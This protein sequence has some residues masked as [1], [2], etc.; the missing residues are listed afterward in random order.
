VT[1]E[2]PDRDLGGG[3]I[4][5]AH[6][7][8][9]LARAMP[10]DLL[11]A[12]ALA[13][14]VTRSALETVVEV[15]R[16]VR[17][18]PRNRTE[19]RLLDLR[20]A[21][22][23]RGTRETWALGPVRRAMAPA[24]E[25][26]CRSSSYDVVVVNHQG[27][28]PLLPVHRRGRWVAHLHNVSADRARHTATTA[29]GARQ[30]WIYDREAAKANRLERWAVAS[31]DAVLVCSD[32]DATALCGPDHSWAKGPV[33]VVPNGVDAARF[34][35]TP[36]PSEP[37]IVLTASLNYLPNV[38]G[39]RWFAFEVL[40]RVQAEVPEVVF[41]VVGRN[42]T[43]DI[44]GLDG[45][46]GIRVHADVPEVAPFLA[47]SRVAVVPL[48]MGTGT[49]LK[50][51]EA[52]AAGRPLVGTT[53]G[54]AGLDLVDGI[55]ARIADD[56]TTLASAVADLLRSD[57]RATALA[58]AGRRLVEERYTWEQ[59]GARLVDAVNAL[60]DGPA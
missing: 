34:V 31:Y 19:R 29:P 4:R 54:L 39:V 28:L 36:L 18:S 51:L 11:V 1:E 21:L 15:P 41:D 8:E 52:L 7:V 33:I 37:R 38:D 22:L 26:L 55:H 6:L 14:P 58:H 53:I 9:A 24:L 56:P 46:H 57:E 48:R 44:L 50:A 10:V 23:E 20:L 45:R 27:L 16:P 32:N 13:D 47:A 42:P 49:R 30:R 3:S 17:R 5:Q 2:S 59:L 12:G 40:P 43:A 60:M 35:P 25:R